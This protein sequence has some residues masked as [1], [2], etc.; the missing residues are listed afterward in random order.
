MTLRTPWIPPLL[1][2]RNSSGTL[3]NS[4]RIGTP[5]IGASQWLDIARAQN[6]LLVGG[7]MQLA[8]WGPHVAVVAAG[9]TETIRAYCWPRPQCFARLWTFVLKGT[10]AFGTITTADGTHSYATNPDV[11]ATVVN[12]PELVTDTTPTGEAISVDISVDPSSDSD[13]ALVVQS[14]TCTEIPL[15]RAAKSGDATGLGVHETSLDKWKQIA[16]LDSSVTEQRSVGGVM[17]VASQNYDGQHALRRKL[18]DWSLLTGVTTSSGSYANLFRVNP[19]CQARQVLGE[20]SRSCRWAVYASASS[21]AGQVRLTSSIDGSTSTISVTSTT[22]AWVQSSAFNCATDDIG[23]SGW[24][25]GSRETC[26]I[27][28][29]AT[30]GNLV[31]YNVAIGER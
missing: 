23:A 16:E 3:S 28:I 20:T 11:S 30:A 22:P 19:S 2:E 9:D 24:V 12:V 14:V 13:V 27:D 26:Q 29:R 15:K 8:G 7:S 25:R 5:P 17:R 6:W 31:I 21:S 4:A 18:F 1:H 10:G